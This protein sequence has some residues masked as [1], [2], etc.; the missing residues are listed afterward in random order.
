MSLQRTVLKPIFFVVIAGVVVVVVVVVLAKLVV[1]LTLVGPV[2]ILQV[3]L[4]FVSIN[5]LY[6]SSKHLPSPFH[7]RQNL[8]LFYKLSFKGILSLS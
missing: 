2:H 4:Q 1:I 6:F 8:N 7:F 3:L 5:V